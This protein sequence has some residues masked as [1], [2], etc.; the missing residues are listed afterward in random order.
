MCVILLFHLTVNGSPL[1]FVTTMPLTWTI[2]QS[3][4]RLPPVLIGGYYVLVQSAM[5]LMEISHQKLHTS[6][7][8]NQHGHRIAP[9]CSFLAIF[10]K[11]IGTMKPGK[12]PLC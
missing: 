8:H 12:T 7:M 3:L 5:F 6:G 2:Y 4:Y 10:K 1:S 9:I 11:R